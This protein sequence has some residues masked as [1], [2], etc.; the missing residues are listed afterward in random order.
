MNKQ[1]IQYEGLAAIARRGFP[2]HKRAHYRTYAETPLTSR[3]GLVRMITDEVV[4]EKWSQLEHVKAEDRWER[5][6]DKPLLAVTTSAPTL[7]DGR[8]SV[9]ALLDH[10]ADYI[11]AEDHERGLK[12]M[13]VP[14]EYAVEDRPY[15]GSGAAE[16]VLLRY[17]GHLPI[18]RR[19]RH[20]IKRCEVCEWFFLDRSRNNGSK[21]CGDKCLAYK[22]KIRQRIRRTGDPRVKRDQERHTL[23]YPFYSPVELREISYYSEMPEQ[24]NLST[25]AE[26]RYAPDY[27]KECSDDMNRKLRHGRVKPKW[28]PESENDRKFYNPRGNVLRWGREWEEPGEI[29]TYNVRDVSPVWMRAREWQNYRNHRHSLD[30]RAI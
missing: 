14:D 13:R 6:T 2:N 18:N 23:G 28:E 4:S 29:V 16:F 12:Q 10:L 8:P 7:I 24:E 20:R 25:N 22:D 27:A 26:S 19:N 21:I 11:L 9:P 30:N 17:Y 15:I 3:I 1:A 5:V